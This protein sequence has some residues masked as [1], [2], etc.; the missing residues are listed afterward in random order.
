MDKKFIITKLCL[1]FL[2]VS[3]MTLK[4]FEYSRLSITCSHKMNFNLCDP[5]N[6]FVAN[7]L[8]D[9]INNIDCFIIAGGEFL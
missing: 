8:K 5:G 1:F 6:F 7:W 2:T 9:I 3:Y 4:Y